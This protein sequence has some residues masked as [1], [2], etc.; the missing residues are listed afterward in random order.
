MKHAKSV[1]L[2]SVKA[3]STDEVEVEIWTDGACRATR[4]LAAGVRC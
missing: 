2:A 3:R 1:A 4:G